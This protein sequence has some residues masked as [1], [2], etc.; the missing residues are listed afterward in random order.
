MEKMNSK[1]IINFIKASFQAL[2]STRANKW[3]GL[4]D[5][6]KSDYVAIKNDWEIIGKDIENI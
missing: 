3:S 2:T 6:R 4:S 5:G 1:A